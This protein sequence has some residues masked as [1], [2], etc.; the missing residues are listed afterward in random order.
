[1]ENLDFGKIKDYLIV[2]NQEDLEF[3]KFYMVERKCM[4]S[5]LKDYHNYMRDL[6]K[7]GIKQV[8]KY[9]EVLYVKYLIQRNCKDCLLYEDFVHSTIWSRK[10]IVKK[11]NMDEVLAFAKDLSSKRTTKRLEYNGEIVSQFLNDINTY[12]TNL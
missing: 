12:C 7:D 6:R 10:S 2:T 4:D 3:V 9:L 11:Y 1:M 8:K 5:I